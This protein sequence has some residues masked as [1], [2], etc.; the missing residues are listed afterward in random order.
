MRLTSAGLLSKGTKPLA[1]GFAF[2][3]IVIGCHLAAAPSELGHPVMRDFP[4]GKSNFG[5]LCQA[6]TQDAAGFI[7]IANGGIAR[8]Y[9]GTT[10]RLIKLP[11]ESAGI[12]KFA[13]SADG[14]IYMGGAGVIGFFR[15]VGDAAEYV[16]LADQLPPTALGCDDIYDVLA[17][18]NT[19]Y[20]A[21]EEKI[22]I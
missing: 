12:R 4:P 17:V 7:Y 16:S 11:T 21:D 19:V 15:G 6:V 14:T 18:G 3:L 20:F 5:H 9:D 2:F 22:L 1:S 8:C 10:W 13:T